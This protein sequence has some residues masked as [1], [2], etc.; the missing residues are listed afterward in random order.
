ME[1]GVLRLD[2]AIREFREELKLSPDDPLTNLR[3]GVA[4]V[5]AKRPAEALPALEIATRDRLAPADAFHYLGRGQLA[6]DR[7]AD[8]VASLRRALELSQVPPID[9]DRLG[10]IQYQLALALRRSGAI[11]EAAIH[12]AEAERASARRADADRERL[13]RYH[14]P[15]V[16]SRNPE[17]L[18]GSP[19]FST[20]TRSP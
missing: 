4:L 13:Q 14:S 20:Y 6:L 10:N 5:E 18:F 16:V 15:A 3:L 2:E 1:E 11:D 7:A 19:A 9:H 17:M 8:A 12:F